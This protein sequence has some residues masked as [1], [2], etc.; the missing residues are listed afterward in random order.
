MIPTPVTDA[1]T[2]IATGDVSWV[3]AN[4][5]R[6]LERALQSIAANTCCDKC[7]EA[8]LVAK[9]ALS[10]H[11]GGCM[12]KWRVMLETYQDFE[13]AS[14]EEAKEKMKAW[15]LERL[16]KGDAGFLALDLDAQP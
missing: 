5:A 9:K 2:R 7:Q 11:R 13:A 12:K 15:L 6:R 14:E 1:Q 16:T 10:T 8:A 4:F 3:H